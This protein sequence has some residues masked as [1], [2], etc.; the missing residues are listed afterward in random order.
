MH[1]VQNTIPACRQD[2][3]VPITGRQMDRTTTDAHSTVSVYAGR[4]EA[5][6]KHTMLSQLVARARVSMHWVMPVDT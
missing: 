3:F 6:L 1:K 4:A 2:T 5:E